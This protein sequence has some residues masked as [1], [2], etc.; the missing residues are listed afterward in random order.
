M[1]AKSNLPDRSKVFKSYIEK[2]LDMTVSIVEGPNRCMSN[3]QKVLEGIVRKNYYTLYSV[4]ILAGNQHC[5]S[6][7]T[8]LSRQVIEDWIVI[9]FMKLKG[10]DKKAKEFIDFATIENSNDMAYLKQLGKTFEPEF[11]E[12][13]KKEF[14][15]LS[16][17]FEFKRGQ[18]SHNWAKCNF[19]S[20]I[21]ELQKEGIFKEKM[22]INICQA[23][24][25]GNRKNHT[26]PIDIL[27]YVFPIELHDFDLL[28]SMN[29]AL[30]FCFVPYLKLSIEFCLEIKN[31]SKFKELVNLL[32]KFNQELKNKE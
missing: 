13:R 5:A 3:F 4:D 14:K 16:K 31:T 9:E 10:K 8:D 2:L 6:T 26:S 7:I 22:Y 15:E 20:M 21:A 28:R 27:N 12:A 32:Y 11:G 18:I 1:E 24:I 25:L 30:T 17:Q 23:Y 19:D 29:T